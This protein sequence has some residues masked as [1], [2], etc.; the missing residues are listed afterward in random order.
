M[1]KSVVLLRGTFEVEEKATIDPDVRGRNF[2]RIDQ[3]PLLRQPPGE[4][5]PW[6]F[7][8][9][10]AISLPVS[11]GGSANTRSRSTHLTL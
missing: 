8:R 9:L 5:A 10:K 4:R 6:T 3:P 7:I 1:R 2:L 11:S